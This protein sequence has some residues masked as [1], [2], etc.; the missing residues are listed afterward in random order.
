MSPALRLHA[1]LP[2]ASAASKTG[3]M[4]ATCCSA[5]RTRPRPW[6]APFLCT[7]PPWPGP[8]RSCRLR[9]AAAYANSG[10]H[11]PALAAIA[12]AEVILAVMG[13][14]AVVCTNTGS[15]L[16]LRGFFTCIHAYM[17]AHRCAHLLCTSHGRP[18]KGS[19]THKAWEEL[20][21]P[22]ALGHVGAAE[23]AG[24]TGPPAATSSMRGGDGGGGRPS[25]HMGRAEGC[26]RHTCT[27][28]VG[29][30]SMHAARRCRVGQHARLAAWAAHVE[31]LPGIPALPVAHAPPP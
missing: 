24:R 12:A 21:L 15:A 3:A 9:S 16:F 8:A 4:P 10:R 7:A 5:L 25:R 20:L 6:L 11:R 30:A 18:V 26:V 27:Q 2:C 28:P 13:S 29:V 22:T 1:G 23:V 17:D 31:P 14:F 19:C